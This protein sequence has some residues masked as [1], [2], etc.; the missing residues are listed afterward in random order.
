MMG[1]V[2]QMKN[3]TTGMTPTSLNGL[4]KV[5]LRT[6]KAMPPFWKERTFHH[7]LHIY[8]VRPIW[9]VILLLFHYYMEGLIIF[10]FTALFLNLQPY[11]ER[12]KNHLNIARCFCQWRKS[13]PYHLLSKGV[14]YPLLHCLLGEKE[15]ACWLRLK[16]LNI[17]L[18]M[19]RSWVWVPA[20]AWLFSTLTLPF[21]II[22]PQRT[23]I[24]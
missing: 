19:Q 7:S 4:S 3:A 16:R 8:N 10:M 20:G 21:E 22:N 23:C 9:Q 2:E 5:R 12:E 1:P 15:W 18:E 17:R 24:D 14:R 11:T 13:S 6:T